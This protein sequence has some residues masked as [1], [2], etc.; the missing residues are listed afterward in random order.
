MTVPEPD[1]PMLPVW[2]LLNDI[3]LL[4]SDSGGRAADLPSGAQEEGPARASRLDAPA[5]ASMDA[6]TGA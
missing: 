1:P 6:N 4:H 3:N 2:L 5:A